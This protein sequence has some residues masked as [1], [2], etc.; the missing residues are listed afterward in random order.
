MTMIVGLTPEGSS[1]AEIHLAGMLARSSDEDVLLCTILPVSW[2]PSPAR[3]DA[4]YRA[5]LER[6]AHETLDAARARLEGTFRSPPS[7]P[8]PAPARRD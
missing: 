5:Y 4:E 3:V 8:R 1:R 6:A 2:P 7:S